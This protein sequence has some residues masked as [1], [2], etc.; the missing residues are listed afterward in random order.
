[1]AQNM[2]LTL[3]FIGLCLVV[4][5]LLLIRWQLKT[6]RKAQE[7]HEKLVQEAKAKAQEQRDYLIESVKVISLAIIDEQCELAEGCIRLKKLLDHLAPQLHRHEDFSIINEMFNATSHMPILDE[8]KKLKL[9]QRFELTQEREAL[10]QQHHDA[11]LEAARK[12]AD[13]R[14]QQ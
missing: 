3:V 14:F 1:M 5:L 4:G 2:F 6:Q 13:Y 7:A 8:W 12:L 11:I 9:K 10:E